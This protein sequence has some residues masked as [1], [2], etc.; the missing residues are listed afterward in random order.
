MSYLLDSD[1]IIFFLRNQTNTINLV[2]KLSTQQ[3]FTSVICIGEVNQGF[4]YPKFK[5]Y[6]KKFNQFLKNIK[7]KDVNQKIMI[8]F[9]KVRH[10]LKKRGQK[11][12]DLD[13]IIAATCIENDLTLVTNNQK[14]FSRIPDLKI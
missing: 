14:H 1:I 13:L 4:L 9:S 6:Q 12:E 8:R 5:T 10:E 11:I 7:I 2:S 3:I